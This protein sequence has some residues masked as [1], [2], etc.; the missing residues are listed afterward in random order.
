MFLLLHMSVSEAVQAN[1]AMVSFQYVA[2]NTP[3]QFPTAI[4]VDGVLVEQYRLQKNNTISF[5]A[6][7][8]T[9]PNLIV[10]IVHEGKVVVQRNNESEFVSID[11]GECSVFFD[12]NEMLLRT[13][14]AKSSFCT[15]IRLSFLQLPHL[16]PLTSSLVQQMQRSAPSAFLLPVS[17]AM[18][19]ILA[20]IQKANVFKNYAQQYTELKVAELLLQL[21]KQVEKNV[22]SF[23]VVGEMLS[24]EELQRVM[25]AKAIITEDLSVHIP[26]VEL[27]RQVGTNESY[28]KKHF[29]IVTGQ[30]IYSFLLEK[31]MKK[32]RLLLKQ[33][34]A[35]LQEIS[36]L[37]GYKR[38]CH[39]LDAFKRYFGI[40]ASSLKSLLLIHWQIVDFFASAEVSIFCA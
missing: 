29:K 28:L 26:I 14:S 12:S 17:I 5:F 27:A 6:D 8:N 10:L 22:V 4:K 9:V 23:T 25:V 3:T 19:F 31:R 40:T 24:K 11:N 39:F 13:I 7:E 20:D 15:A 33:E 21:S 38:K 18:E 1:D 34:Q 37:T 35:T 16:A 32:A 36:K 2:Q 30:T